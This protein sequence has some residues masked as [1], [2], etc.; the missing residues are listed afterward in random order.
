MKV[1]NL[2]HTAVAAM[3]LATTGWGCS[4][5]STD[6]G[7]P[8]VPADG[9]ASRVEVYMA[10][11]SAVA[12]DDAIDSDDELMHTWWVAF[13]NG[14]NEVERIVSRD[15]SQTGAVSEDR[16]SLELPNGIYR[17]YA[18]ANITPAQ[19][20]QAAGVEFVEGEAAPAMSAAQWSIDLNEWPANAPET[21]TA[22][23]PMT[24]YLADLQVAQSSS[25]E[26]EVVRLV[27]KVRFDII[28]NTVASTANVNSVTIS[29][30]T[31]GPCPLLPD[32]TKL[33]GLYVPASPE[34]LT[35][36]ELTLA[37][38]EGQTS[39]W[40]YLRESAAADGLPAPNP[41]GRFRLRVSVSRNGAPATDYFALTEELPALSRNDY[42]TIP[43][44]LTDYI[45]DVD[46][47]FYPPI[48]GYPAVVVD[49]LGD[50]YTITFGSTGYF[51]ITPYVYDAAG[52]A[53]GQPLS[54]ETI[55]VTAVSDPDGIFATP[56][57][58]NPSDG[59]IVGELGTNAG[60]AQ[61]DLAVTVRQTPAVDYTFTR[62]IRIIRQ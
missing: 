26:I 57:D 27:A 30:V 54:P 2:L 38:A 35:Y 37:F 5:S 59:E 17:V 58:Y 1:T 3:L 32:Y 4:S 50:Y 22:A 25:C 46:V 33:G 53:N 40:T 29:P 16:F 28:D 12:A 62:T 18:F 51:S 60:T 39:A 21:F 47:S 45:L 56:P 6:E 19:L 14:R 23:L 10:T 15:P 43:L 7:D 44:M 8:V 36:R 61:V 55:A 34:G 13:V 11:G 31:V 9:A 48:G 20:R 49:E 24:G 42:V 52:A 41:T